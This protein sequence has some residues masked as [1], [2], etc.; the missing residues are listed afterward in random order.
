MDQFIADMADGSYKEKSHY[1]PMMP[2]YAMSKIGLHALTFIQHQEVIAARPNDD[3][4]INVVHTG[5]IATE[6]N[7]KMGNTTPDEGAKSSV[8][9]ALLP[10]G[11]KVNGKYLWSDC[12]ERD[13]VDG[14][15]GMKEYMKIIE[16]S[17]VKLPGMP[18]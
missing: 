11:T 3:I 15:N 5:L 2:A 18:N 4:V 6:I 17:Q 1:P 14:D 9:A 10:Q 7:G 12:T 8:Y 13:W 16:E